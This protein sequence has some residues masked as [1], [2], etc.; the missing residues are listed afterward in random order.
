[1]KNSFGNF[2]FSDANSTKISIKNNCQKFK[3]SQDLSPKNKIK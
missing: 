3:I 2:D 1:M